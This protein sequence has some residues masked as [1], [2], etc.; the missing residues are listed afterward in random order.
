LWARQRLLEAGHTPKTPVPELPALEDTD[1]YIGYGE[2]R[3]LLSGA[4]EEWGKAFVALARADQLHAA[5]WLEESR[6]ELRIAADQYINGKKRM[7]GGDVSVPRTESYV[8]GVGWRAEWSYPKPMPSKEGRAVLRSSEESEALRVALRELTIALEEPN[9]LGKLTP[10]DELGYRTR[11]HLRAFRAAIEREGHARGIDP[12]H[13][14]AL[15]YTESRFRRH[16]VSY[17]GA[18]GALQIMPWTGRQ[19]EER[20]GLLELGQTFD[21][22]V[23]YDIDHNAM[24]SSYYVS[25][26]MK[27]FHGQATMA[28]ASY[29]GGPH[30]VGRWLEAKAKADP[31]AQPLGL[32]DF[33]EEIPFT[34]THRYARRVM[35]VHA[36]YSLMYR[37]ELPTWTTETDGDCEDNIDF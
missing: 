22:D 23:L 29:N 17:V 2:T 25:E 12:L 13:L 5:G 37:G 11:W 7:S 33:V 27:K 36:A 1:R 4:T 35:E 20:L 34:E 32:D 9:R 30:N 19:L 3:Q 8:Q 15:M 6:R 24:L 14:W 16:V 28:Y 21:P 31:A 18:R 26:L 10:W